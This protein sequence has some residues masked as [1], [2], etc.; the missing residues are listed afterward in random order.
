MAERRWLGRGHRYATLVPGVRW[1]P[2]GSPVPPGPHYR[3]PPSRVAQLAERPAVNRQVTGSS[4]VAGAT[5]SAGS[6]ADHL[7]G[8]AAEEAL[9]S[10]R[11]QR[12]LAKDP[13]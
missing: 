2:L 10:A 4:P 1:G 5:W 3:A 11:R 8:R 6:A 12:Q 13:R 9:G 7:H